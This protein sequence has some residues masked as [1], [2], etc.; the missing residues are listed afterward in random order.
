[1]FI[2]EEAVCRLHPIGVPCSGLVSHQN[3]EHLRSASSSGA[4]PI[5]IA[6]LRSGA[7]C[8]RTEAFFKLRDKNDS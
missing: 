4:A 1:M 7:P 3:M 8:S 5:N 6:L 2:D